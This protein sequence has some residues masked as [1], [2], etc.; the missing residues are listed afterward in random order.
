MGNESTISFDVISF[1]LGSILTIIISFITHKATENAN[2]KR[3]DRNTMISFISNNKILIS[4]SIASH[5][6]NKV[7][8]S[9]LRKELNDNIYTFFILP[10]EYKL[11]V[12]NI[13]ECINLNGKEMKDNENSILNNLDSLYIKLKEEGISIGNNK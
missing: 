9:L 1:V 7:D 10:K 11:I 8:Y 2:Q 12:F 3:E 5:F 4:S 6:N 13:Y